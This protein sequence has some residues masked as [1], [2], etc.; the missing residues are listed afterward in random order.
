MVQLSNTR[1]ISRQRER[2]E[3][4]RLEILRAAARVF[5]RRGFA[6]SGMREIA[7]EAD[8][9]PGNL[10][11]YFA[12]KEEI[13][14]FCQQRSLDA[15]M[16]ELER[17]TDSPLSPGRQLHELI[18]CHVEVLLDS[19]EGSAAHLELGG[20]ESEKRRELVMRRQAYERGIREIVERG[21][22]DGSFVE[23]DADLVTK[24]ILGAI[25]WP[26]LW[27]KRDSGATPEAIGATLADYL[28]RG[29]G[30]NR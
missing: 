11:H 9:S 20:L 28:V 5:R 18:R 3:A 2:S 1:S 4:R 22:A 7:A 24:A 12:G 25:N 15:L 29:L 23:A 17:V 16:A 27:F 13:L 21:I 30:E 10:Y 6:A 14:F 8:L 19:M 26:A